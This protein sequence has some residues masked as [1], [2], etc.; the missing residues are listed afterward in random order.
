MNKIHIIGILSVLV[1][2][3]AS[4]CSGFSDEDCC[5]SNWSF[6]STEYADFDFPELE[7]LQAVK[8]FTP[9]MKAARN[10]FVFNE[11]FHFCVS[12]FYMGIANEQARLKPRDRWSKIGASVAETFGV[13]PLEKSTEFML[14]T[15]DPEKT[16]ERYSYIKYGFEAGE[17]SYLRTVDT[18]KLENISNFLCGVR[19]YE[20]FE[21]SGKGEA[22]S[23]PAFMKQRE[24]KKE[25][26]AESESQG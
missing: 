1:I 22:T 18:E 19:A 16:S 10:D 26:S 11:A 24:E 13:K 8:I 7:S 14:N 6:V 5:I 21:K 3:A 9:Q 23:F 15:I 25:S 4:L 17:Y 20:A 2:A 12:G